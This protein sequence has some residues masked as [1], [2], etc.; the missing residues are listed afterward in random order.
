MVLFI[1]TVI[2]SIIGGNLVEKNRVKVE[3]QVVVVEKN[4]VLKVIENFK[5]IIIVNVEKVH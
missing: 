4:R 5:L 2:H 1:H 3:N